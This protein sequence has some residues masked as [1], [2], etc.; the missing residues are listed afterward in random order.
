MPSP[1]VTRALAPWTSPSPG[2]PL[3]ELLRSQVVAGIELRGAA[4]SDAVACRALTAAIHAESAA[5]DLPPLVVLDAHL[6]PGEGI[7]PDELL[8]PDPGHLAM[9]LAAGGEDFEV[10]LKVL[11][12]ARGIAGLGIDLVLSPRLD[13]S[14]APLDEPALTARLSAAWTEALLAAGLIACAG[15]LGADADGDEA[16]AP[17]GAALAHGLEAVFMDRAASVQSVETLRGRADDLVVIGPPTDDPAQILSGARSGIDLL[18]L[19]EGLSA[20]ELDAIFDS[21]SGGGHSD[22]QGLNRVDALRE[23]WLV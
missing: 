23:D 7:L 17:F 6:H 22:R 10:T 3:R 15:P 21:A 11:T 9:D 20:E 1:P 16:W 13:R 4:L 2:P 12:W 18:R 8:P 14:A 19:A 5:A